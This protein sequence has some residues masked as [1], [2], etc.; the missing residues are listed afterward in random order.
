MMCGKALNRLLWRVISTLNGF[1]IRR[2]SSLNIKHW[3]RRIRRSRPLSWE[4]STRRW[5]LLFSP[6]TVML[7]SHLRR[8]VWAR[9][10]ATRMTMFTRPMRDQSSSN[11]N[12]N[13]TLSLTSFPL[14]INSTRILGQLPSLRRDG[15]RHWTPCWGY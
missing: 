9:Q 14:E 12:T 3:R 5:S 8:A 1:G 4:R 2:T 15:I 13:S 6:R 11:A 7:F 10:W